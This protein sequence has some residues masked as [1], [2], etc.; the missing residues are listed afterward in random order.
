MKGLLMRVS[1]KPLFS[2]FDGLFATG[3]PL[4]PRRAALTRTRSCPIVYVMAGAVSRLKEAIAG[5][6]KEK[7]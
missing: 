6:A 4:R 2:I 1:T 5:L 7:S 3:P